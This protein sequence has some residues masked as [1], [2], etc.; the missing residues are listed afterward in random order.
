MDPVL[1]ALRRAAATGLMPGGEAL[2]LA[3]SGGADSTA[4]LQAAA[5]VARETGWA[6]SVGHVH[7]GWR[8]DDADRDLAFVSEQARRLGLP[9][10]ARREDARAE[11][12]RLGLSPE[13]AARHVRY[14]AL[15]EIARETG[16]TLIATAHQRDDA[17]E[18][19]RIGLARRGGVRRLAGPRERREDGVVRPLL[20][21]WRDE[22]LAF[23]AA[24]SI[25]WR[26]DATNGDLRLDRNRVRR[27]LAALGADERRA[28]AEEVA[29]Y[30][31]RADR[32]EAELAEAILPT[33]HRSHPEGRLEADA[34]PLE[35]AG[36]EL[37]RLAI[38]RLAAPFA[39]PG[40]APTTGCE[41][42]TLVARLGSGADF[43][44]EAGRRIRFERRGN[45]LRVWAK[46]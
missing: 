44:F 14:R 41:R 10:A 2:L 29:A 34:R 45:R 22:I 40:R 16:A 11:A 27:E 15:A 24:R 18:S 7:H 31:E 39:R 28:I 38:D 30:R 6:L 33:V 25:P 9:F 3:V 17:I 5:E 46:A 37:R 12:R 36:E 1:S 4:L 21:V 23:L 20:S 35:A 42:E 19:H 32:L 26:R 8:G 13:A 43:R